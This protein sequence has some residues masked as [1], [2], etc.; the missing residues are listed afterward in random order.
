MLRKA[1]LALGLLV[2]WASPLLGQEW[3]QKMFEVTSHD[4]GSVARGAKSE[5]EFVLKNLYVEDVHISSVR[6]SCSCTSPTIKNAWLKTYETGAIVARFNTQAFSGRRGAT[7][8]VSIDKPF[9]AKVRLQVKGHIRS[10]VAIH[11]GSVLLGAVG[12]GAAVEKTVTVSHSGRSDWRIVD[13][14]SPNPHLSA[15]ATKTGRRGGKVVYE[16]KVR[17]DETAPPGYLQD[18]LMLVT[19]DRRA[20]RVPLPVEGVVQSGITVS[21]ESLF[22]GVVAPGKSVTRQLVVKSNRPF[23]IVAISC[24]DACFQFDTP[25][26]PA[27]KPLHLIPVTFVAG[28]TPGK[29]QQRIRIETDL[30]QSAPELSAYAVVAIPDSRP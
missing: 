25:A 1:A 9:R 18:H 27:S 24:G 11:P 2:T 19:N 16:V 26:E 5:F 4:F 6:A 30:G 12:E 13:V 17:L 15:T 10:D 23:R 8:T 7:I 21:P 3:A 29:V 28:E 14:E 20:T 22:L